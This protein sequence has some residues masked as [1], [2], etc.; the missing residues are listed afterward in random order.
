MTNARKVPACGEA[1]NDALHTAARVL[2]PPGRPAARS[3]V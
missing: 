2:G 1:V 3:V